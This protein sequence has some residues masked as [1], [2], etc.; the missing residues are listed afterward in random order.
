[1]PIH[2]T[3]GLH[4]VDAAR[5]LFFNHATSDLSGLLPSPLLKSWE[6][7]RHF[8]L[9]ANDAILFDTVSRTDQRFL[10]EK[11][12][13]L[14]TYVVPELKRLRQVCADPGLVFACLDANATVI[15]AVSDPLRAGRR[16]SDILRT[17]LS[18]D[19]RLVGTTAPGCALHD[20]IATIVRASEH[21]LDEARNFACAAV[22]I[23]G[24]NGRSIGCIDAT[25]TVSSDPASVLE[26]MM[27]AANAIQNRM[28]CDLPEAIVIG[29]HP[30][31]A[32]LDTPMQALIALTPDGHVVGANQIARQYLRFGQLGDDELTCEILFEKTISQ[33]MR[34]L[35]A[36][37][38]P[39]SSTLIAAGFRFQARLQPISGAAQRTTARERAHLPAF[40]SH[41]DR[42]G[43]ASSLNTD[44]DTYCF[45]DPSLNRTLNQAHLVFSRDIPIILN[46][47]TGTGK[48][49]VAR[50]LHQRGPRR[51][52]P[53]IAVN[54]AALPAGLIESEL[55]GY[56]DGAFTGGRRGGAPGKFEQANNGTLLLDEIG[57]M[58]L[59]MQGRLL[60]ALQE[61]AIVRIGGTRSIPLDLSVICAT[62]RD[63]S[64]L[65]AQGRFR[66]DL[67]FRLQGLQL[68]LPPLRERA[69]LGR[70]MDHLVATA[71]RDSHPLQWHPHARKAMLAYHWPGN[72]RQLAHVIQLIAVLAEHDGEIRR[73]HL[74]DDIV[75][76]SDTPLSDPPL[77]GATTD[78]EDTGR[79]MD[80]IQRQA[81]LEA[82]ARHHGNRAAAARSLGISR[83]TLYRKLSA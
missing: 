74:P 10:Q 70:L 42:P 7:S 23:F 53:F 71:C 8:G 32:M 55:F 19:E 5:R 34:Q 30:H 59:D 11:H 16:L 58:P 60:R 54:C 14:L 27:L 76:L 73:E 29:L 78:V 69:D 79:S 25:S 49:V 12:A 43:R 62:H 48:E 80:A 26:P 64:T 31:P 44:L 22:P 4:S 72:V 6:R 47:E 21:F 56:E 41:A 81:I 45:Q 52:G 9:S 13:D 38:P 17:G 36:S 18:L 50:A 2:R 33:L 51:N 83:A 63:L 77:R 65:A 1:M 39:D 61:R 82:I 15:H 37:S 67:L 24:P 66:P 40:A 68:T 75:A 35:Q 57:D 3:D 46:G 20:G 28:I